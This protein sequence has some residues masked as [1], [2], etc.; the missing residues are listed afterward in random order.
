M[1]QN[2]HLREAQR[3][4]EASLHTKGL[5]PISINLQAAVGLKKGYWDPISS[6]R[7]ALLTQL[8]SL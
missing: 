6:A 7:S 5:N 4:G 8:L 1:R 2:H 3:S